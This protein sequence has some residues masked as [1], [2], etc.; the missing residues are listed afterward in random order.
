MFNFVLWS[1]KCWF[2]FNSRIL[3]THFASIMTLNHS[4]IIAETRSYI[5]RLRSRCRRCR[6]S[7]SSV[8]ISQQA[9]DIMNFT[10]FWNENSVKRPPSGYQIKAPSLIIKFC[11]MATWKHIWGYPPTRTRIPTYCGVPWWWKQPTNKQTIEP[12][13]D[14]AGEPEHSVRALTFWAVSRVTEL[15]FKNP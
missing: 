11:C 4:E 10:S 9:R 1:Q 3:R 2:Q 15:S 12:T 14:T 6:V 5:F 7:L 8:I 13:W